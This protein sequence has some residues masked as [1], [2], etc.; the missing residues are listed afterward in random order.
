MPYII[1]KQRKLL[2]PH[3]E[4]LAE[5]IQRIAEECEDPHAFAG[6]LN[7]TCTR[8]AIKLMPERRY[9]VIALITGIFKNIAD[10]FYRRVGVPYEDEQIKKNGDVY[11]TTKKQRN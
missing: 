6:L 11:D 5:E 4:R 10:E 9:W 8:L 1:P 3:I 7:Y 2:D